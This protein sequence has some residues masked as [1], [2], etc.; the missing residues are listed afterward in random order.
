MADYYTQ[1]SVDI[2]CRTEA[3]RLWLLAHLEEA[4]ES[5]DGP[6]CSYEDHTED[7][8]IW[9]YAEENGEVNRLSELVAL[10]QETFQIE[11][12]WTLTWANTC[13][14]MRCDSFSGGLLIVHRGAIKTFNLDALA[15]R[16]ATKREARYQKRHAK[17]APSSGS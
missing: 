11:K 10:F 15:D 14:R 2:P 5:E 3:E 13:S 4:D 6:I 9:C 17:Q 8:A 7:S 1:F 16:W 12:P